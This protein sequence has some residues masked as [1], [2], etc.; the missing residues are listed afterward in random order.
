MEAL[1]TGARA[2]IV[3]YAGGLETEQTLRAALLERASGIEVVA[4]AT[5]NPRAIARAAAKALAAPRGA[6]PVD[7]DGAD[8]SARLLASLLGRRASA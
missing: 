3:P 1:A 4:E 2:V 6:A 8:V 7:T 5:L